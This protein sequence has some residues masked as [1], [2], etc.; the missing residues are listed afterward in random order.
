MLLFQHFL[1]PGFRKKDILKHCKW[2]KTLNLIY[3]VYKKETRLVHY[4]HEKN[5][6][7]NSILQKRI[8]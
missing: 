4:D 6:S 2:T 8:N 1:H 3:D 5:I 7:K